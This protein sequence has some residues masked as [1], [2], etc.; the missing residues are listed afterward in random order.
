MPVKMRLFIP[1]RTER[2]QT[3]MVKLARTLVVAFA[4]LPLAIAVVDGNQLP[5]FPQIE[6]R[7]AS[8]ADAAI[9]T[10][11]TI[12]AFRDLASFRYVRQFYDQYPQDTFDCLHAEVLKEL[13]RP[14]RDV[15]GHLGLV[16]ANEES[17]EKTAVSASLWKLPRSS[18]SP[19]M[20]EALINTFFNDE[21][22][23]RDL[24]LTRAV[25]AQRQLVREKQRYLDDV[26]PEDQQLYL[27]SI[28]TIPAYQGHDIAGH[29]LRAGLAMVDNDAY[30]HRSLYATLM[31]TPAGEPLYR[32]NGFTSIKNISIRAL[33]NYGPFRFD[34]MVKQLR[35]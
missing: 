33:D 2:P 9:I 24:N 29:V 23:N 3:I 8:S 14:E 28:G 13:D 4:A 32:E 7:R 17:H 1:L 20:A 15:V 34:V 25:D 11:I 21:C 31:A 5:L 27:G 26:Y 12:A 16:P 19:G 30:K 18:S 6:V 22:K 10:N 35:P